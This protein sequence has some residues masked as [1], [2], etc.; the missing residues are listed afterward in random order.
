MRRLN[1]DWLEAQY[2]QDGQALREIEAL[3][4]HIAGAALVFAGFFRGIHGGLD[5]SWAFEDCDACYIGVNGIAHREE[6]AALG[7]YVLDDVA[8]YATVRKDPHEQALLIIDEFGVLESTNAT[9]LYEQV[10]EAGLCVYASGQS[11]QSL[12]R[13]RENVLAAS[14]IKILHR[15]GNPEPLFAYAGKRETFAFSIALTEDQENP[16]DLYHPYANKP[17]AAGGYMREQEEDAVPLEDVQQLA[18]GHIV[19]IDGG[20]HAFLQVQPLE[21]PDPLVQAARDAIIQAGHYQPLP[22]LPP[23][24]KQKEKAKDGKRKK[25]EEP[26]TQEA[27]KPCAPPATPSV[28][29]EKQPVV[30]LSAPRETKGPFAVP[31]AVSSEE[32]GEDADDFFH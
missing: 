31:P 27:R 1:H 15:S 26:K 17:G 10:R 2:A 21:I 7:R 6:A 19:L 25:R 23:E 14:S 22:P 9:A 13:E 8:H 16:E 24:P 12:G 11:Y 5:G 3:A 29:V 28:P 20:Q 18:P 30:K 4:P 32:A